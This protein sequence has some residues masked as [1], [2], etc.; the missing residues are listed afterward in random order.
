MTDLLLAPQAWY[1]D[2]RWLACSWGLVQVYV[3]CSLE[4]TP[5]VS[6]LLSMLCSFLLCSFL[7]LVLL[8]RAVRACTRLRS[9]AAAANSQAAGQAPMDCCTEQAHGLSPGMAPMAAGMPGAS[10]WGGAAGY[11][12]GGMGAA[13]LP[14]PLGSGMVWGMPVYNVAVAPGIVPPQQQPATGSSTVGT[15]VAGHNAGSRSCSSAAVDG[16]VCL[17]QSSQ[18]ARPHRHAAAVPAAVAAGQQQGCCPATMPQKPQMWPAMWGGMC[19]P[20]CYPMWSQNPVWQQQNPSMMT[21]M[22]QYP[23]VNGLKRPL[24]AAPA[25]AM[26]GMAPL[27][28][29]TGSSG[30]PQEQQ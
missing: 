14:G 1:Q 19:F 25:A 17:Q 23:A 8:L 11:L 21:M 28:L 13:P 24:V 26:P 30:V 5:M 3:C 12:G 22:P 4:L 9:M 27:Q 2:M 6:S 10:Q 15:A 20:M 16:A 7:L 18:G 29:A